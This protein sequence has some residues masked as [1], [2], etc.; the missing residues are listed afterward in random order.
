M[1]ITAAYIRHRRPVDYGVTPGTNIITRRRVELLRRFA[2]VVLGQ[3]NGALADPEYTLVYGDSTEPAFGCGALLLATASGTV[4]GIVNGV[5]LTATA[6]GGDIPSAALIA[7]AINASTDPLALGFV[8]S[9]NL[10]ATLTLTSVLAGAT[11]DIAGTRFTARSGTGPNLNVSGSAQGFFDMSGTDTADAL[12][13]ATAINQCPGASRFVSALAVANVVHLMARRFT[14]AA[15]VFSWPTSPGVPANS[16]ISQATT[17]VASGP[18]FVASN[19]VHINACVPG[20]Q[21]NAVTVA[22]SGTGVTVLGTQARLVGGL[23]LNA[24]SITDRS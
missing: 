4:G 15:G 6:A 8:T 5:T 9:N 20:V 22:L 14:F 12:S 10:G 24:V 17:I 11:V 23:G 18:A 13:L 7:T 21:G 2:N 3:I 19:K 1:P 16:V